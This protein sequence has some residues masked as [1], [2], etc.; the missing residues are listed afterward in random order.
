MNNPITAIFYL[1]LY[2]LGLLFVLPFSKKIP[3]W[4]LVCTGFLW[5]LLIWTFCSVLVLFLNISFNWVIMGLLIGVF[6]ITAFWMNIQRKTYMLTGKQ[7]LTIL[8]GL[9]VFSLLDFYLTQKSYIYVT[10][11]SFSIIYHGQVLGKSGLAPWAINQFTEWGLISPVIQMTSLILPG[12]YLTGHQTLLAASL[13]IFFGI[14][15]FLI[16][17]KQYSTLVAI[18]LCLTIISVLGSIIMIEH[19]FYL[20]SN[21]TAAVYLF[22]SLFAYWKFLQEQSP[23]WLLLASIAISAFGFSRI[24]GPLYM[25]LFQILVISIKEMDYKNRLLVILP[26]SI[27]FLFWYGFLYFSAKQPGLLDK[28]NILIIIASL[29]LF[30]ALAIIS[31]WIPK[32]IS[33]LPKLTLGILIIGLGLTFLINPEHMI[34]STSSVYQNLINQNSWGLTWII[35]A[36]FL[37]LLFSQ[38]RDQPEN[39]LY[40][41]GIPGYIILVLFLGFPRSPYRLGAT[42]SANRLLLQIQPIIFLFIIM[43]TC[44]LNKWLMIRTGKN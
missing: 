20:H 1:G 37:P 26:S 22:V 14:N 11:D 15:I 3:L 12:D 6:F 40:R 42:D 44:T 17:H 8:L 25:M 9:T 10:A 32:I 19:T 23:E 33:L 39:D 28:T 35:S 21:L 31:R 13:L 43:K 2:C 41:F 34:T 18:L 5:G 7:I 38:N 29:I 27:I 36:A 24:E 16:F 30:S 4:V